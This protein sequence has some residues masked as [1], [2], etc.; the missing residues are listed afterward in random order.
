M[1]D[2][3]GKKQLLHLVLGGELKKLSDRL[4]GLLRPER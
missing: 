1:A 3:G 4:T 2:A